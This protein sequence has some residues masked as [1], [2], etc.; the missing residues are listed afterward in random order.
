MNERTAPRGFAMHSNAL[1]AMAYK[2]A[3]RARDA[4]AAAATA[5]AV[6]YLT[7][8]SLPAII[9]ASSAAEGFLND[10][11]EI[12]LHVA[13]AAAGTPLTP[14]FA[15][16]VGIAE[17]L[18]QL[19]EERCTVRAKYLAAG[20][21][22][23]SSGIRKGSEPFQ[24]FDDLYALRN[25]IVHAKPLPFESADRQS[26]IANSLAQRGLANPLKR[27]TPEAIL[28]DTWLNQIQ[29]PQTA[30]WAANSAA[31]IM[32]KL[33][34]SFA[35]SGNVGGIYKQQVDAIRTMQALY[36]AQVG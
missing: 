9:M 17:A 33:G 22:F 3:A 24:S 34:E 16:L 18:D 32:I 19:K 1:L 14:D 10:A 15:R 6:D 11:V 30:L 23:A 27:S 28:G 5:G 31:A 35:D 7:E 21:F 26:R 4:A 13:A 25:G 2:S 20:L 8:D 29:T 36:P 12:V